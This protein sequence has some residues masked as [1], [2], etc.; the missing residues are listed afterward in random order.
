VG[1]DDR[2][3]VRYLAPAYITVLVTVEVLSTLTG[4]AAPSLGPASFGAVLVLLLLHALLCWERPFRHVPLV[5]A[6]APALRLAL[7][8]AMVHPP[9]VLRS[10]ALGLPVL[11]ATGV[12]LRIL[13]LF[14]CWHDAVQWAGQSLQE[15]LDSLRRRTLPLQRRLAPFGF[16]LLTLPAITL[17]VAVLAGILIAHSCGIQA[18]AAALTEDSGQATVRR[19]VPGEARIQPDTGSPALTRQAAGGSLR[20]A[21]PWLTGGLRSHAL[22]WTHG[23]TRSLR[24]EAKRGPLPQDRRTAKDTA[25]RMSMIE[26]VRKYIPTVLGAV[27]TWPALQEAAA[28]RNN[29]P[30]AAKRSL[31]VTTRGLTLRQTTKRLWDTDLDSLAVAGSDT[32]SVRAWRALEAQLAAESS[33]EPPS[34]TGTFPNCPSSGYGNPYPRGVCTWYAKDRRPDLPGFWG[35]YGLAANWPYAAAACGFRVDGLPA[36]GAVIV[37]PAGANGAYEG[38]H[39]SYVEAVEPDVLFIS[40]CNVDHDSAG[41]VEPRW[42]ESGYA[43]AYRRIPWARLD[44]R[45]QYIHRWNEPL[46]TPP[47]EPEVRSSPA[48]ERSREP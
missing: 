40:E 22:A 7:S 28:T 14:P 31:V 48:L 21:A 3:Q 36:A 9:L 20:L 39:V 8:L 47:Q 33:A 38:G 15:A 44:P 43:C 10:L 32:L 12:A 5:L 45:V 27:R 29:R 11:L 25:G 26:A 16:S 41:I 1:Q 35:D 34:P 17:L 19:S 46:P 13:G 18:T 42:W 23:S 2:Q 4:A 6:A 24:T 30:L 37:F